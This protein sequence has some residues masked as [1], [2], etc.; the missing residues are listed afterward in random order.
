NNRDESVLNTW[1][2]GDLKKQWDGDNIYWL[3]TA[4]I[5]SAN[6]SSALGSFPLWK[7]CAI[8]AV[9]MLAAETYLLAGGFRKQAATQ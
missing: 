7:V 9:L 5:S 3:S 6:H 2:I 1:A 4:E 8:L